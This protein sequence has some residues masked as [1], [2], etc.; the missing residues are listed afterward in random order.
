MSDSESPTANISNIAFA[1]VS[2]ISRTLQTATP[3]HP[4]AMQQRPDC[5]L[6]PSRK[7]QTLQIIVNG[8]CVRAGDA[9]ATVQLVRS[10]ADAAP[11]VVNKTMAELAVGDR[12]QVGFTCSAAK[13]VHY[14]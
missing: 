12:V 7:Y 13:N 14:L 11:W 4:D 6:Y 10:P 9:M 1:S 3:T 2:S 8:F 5:A